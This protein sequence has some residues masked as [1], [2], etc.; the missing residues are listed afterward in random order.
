[1][2][3]V[4]TKDR[5]QAILKRLLSE[6]EFLSKYGIRSLSKFHQDNPYSYGDKKEHTI[7]YEPAES[8]GDLFGGNSNWRGP[9]WLPLNFIII[10]SLQKFHYYYGDDFKTEFPAGSGNMV[11]LWDVAKLI[12]KRLINLF[13]L[14]DGKR[15]AHGKYDILQNNKWFKDQIMFYEYFHG[16]NGAGLGSSH[17][18]WTAIVTKLI[19]QYGME[20]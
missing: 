18:G 11:N 13:V 10:E 9:I 1:M 3:S 7:R 5:L 16:E 15:V 4:L 19:M 14:K 2:L 12:A 8:S 20:E 6:D 17:Q